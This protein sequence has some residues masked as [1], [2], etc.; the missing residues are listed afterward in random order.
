MATL[1]RLLR[2][3]KD[4]ESFGSALVSL[5]QSYKH[6]HLAGHLKDFVRG[7]GGG[8]EEGERA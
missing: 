6:R 2:F 5:Q 7:G 8:R 3:V 1:N 4:R